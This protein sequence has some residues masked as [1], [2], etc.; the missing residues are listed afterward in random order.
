MIDLNRPRYFNALSELV[1]GDHNLTGGSTDGPM[2][3]IGFTDGIKKP[4]ESAVQTKLAELQAE[5]DA[6]EYQRSRALEY[7]SI[8]D[9]LDEIYHNGIDSWKAVIKKTKDKHP[10]E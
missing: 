8:P 9:Q 3:K 6:N 1:G 7:P 5:S 4:T 2:S 10:K